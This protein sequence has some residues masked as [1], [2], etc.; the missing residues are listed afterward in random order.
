MIDNGLELFGSAVQ[1]GFAVLEKFD[2]NGDGVISE[3]DADFGKLR[4]W[5]DLNQDGASQPGELQTLAESGISSISLSRRAVGST[6]AGNVIGYEASFLRADG[7]TGL[8]QSIYFQTDGQDTTDNTPGFTPAEGVSDLPSLPGA[9][10]IHSIAYTA[11]IDSSFRLAWTSLTDGAAGMDPA[12][13][14]ESFQTLL[15]RWAGV[16]GVDSRSRGPNVDARHLAF[17]E[18]FFGTTYAELTPH[19]EV[20][21]YP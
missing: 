5:R 13:F 20:R 7:S 9:G 19:E 8:V 12:T 21:T 17:L 1:D 4:I 3:L 6:N 10:T 16:D 2:T 14:R 15:L 11:T 18:A